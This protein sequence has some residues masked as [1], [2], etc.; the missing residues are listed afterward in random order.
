MPTQNIVCPC[1]DGNG[2]YVNPAIDE[3][4]IGADDEC[5]QDD[6]FRE[7]YM[8]G[9]YDVSCEEC[10]GRNVVRGIDPSADPDILKAWEDWQNEEHAYRAECAAE[11]AM[12]A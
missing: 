8:S 3:H 9:T 7:G 5:W 2:R 11:R 4:G 10:Q 6:D 12:G 1:C